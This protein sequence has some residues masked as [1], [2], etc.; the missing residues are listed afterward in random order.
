MFNS[1]YFWWSNIRKKKSC[2]LILIMKHHE[3]GIGC[4]LLIMMINFDDM[5]LIM[6][7]LQPSLPPLTLACSFYSTSNSFHQ[8]FSSFSIH[9]HFLPFSVCV[10]VYV[11]VCIGVFLWCKCVGNFFFKLQ[12]LKLYFSSRKQNSLNQIIYELIFGVFVQP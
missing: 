8:A 5:M 2:I 9:S 3:I 4:W 12:L 11:S 1:K 7:M 10:C 6:M